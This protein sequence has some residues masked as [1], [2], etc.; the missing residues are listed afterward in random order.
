MTEAKHTQG[1][2]MI[3]HSY[4]IVAENGRR[5][6]A[7]A[8]GYQNNQ[9]TEAVHAENCANARLIAAAPDLL[10]ALK[11]A[12]PYVESFD[13]DNADRQTKANAATVRAAIARATGSEATN[14]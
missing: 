3:I 5:G 1:P 8:G 12:L 10:A 13:G 2:W 7:S 4:N 14:G 9:K 11:I 6:I